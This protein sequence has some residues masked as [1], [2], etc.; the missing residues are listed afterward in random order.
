VALVKTLREQL[1]EVEAE[2]ERLRQRIAAAAC[3]EA[4]C[5]MVLTGG[6]NAGCSDDCCCSV[7]VHTCARCGVSD[8]GDNA[9][10]AA[11]IEACRQRRED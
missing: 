2:A 4:G 10:A 8:H 9:D 11:T 1:A 7:P 5:D 3:A 6:C